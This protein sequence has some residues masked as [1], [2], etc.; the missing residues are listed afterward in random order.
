MSAKSRRSSRGNCKNPKVAEKVTEPNRS[1]IT[2]SEFERQLL[3]ALSQ[4]R[5]VEPKPIDPKD[6]KRAARR[7]ARE[8][9]AFL[10]ENPTQDHMQVAWEMHEWEMHDLDDSHVPFAYYSAY[11]ETL[12]RQAAR[13]SS[14]RRKDKATRPLHRAAF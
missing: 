1:G 5:Q 6:L 14:A 9:R 2:P 8:A 7:G 11:L 12:E 4:L 13:L 3:D 10:A